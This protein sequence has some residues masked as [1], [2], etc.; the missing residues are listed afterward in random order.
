MR[1]ERSYTAKE[2]AEAK[3]VSYATARRWIMEILGDDRAMIPKN[4]GRG[5]RPKRMRRLPE[6]KLPELEEFMNH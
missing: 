5:K 6:S 1:L 3:R 2:I 4:K